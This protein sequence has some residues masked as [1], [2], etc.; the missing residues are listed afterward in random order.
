MDIVEEE[1][2]ACRGLRQLRVR[3]RSLDTKEKIDWTLKLWKQGRQKK[4]NNTTLE[5]EESQQEK[6]NEGE[7]DEDT[8]LSDSHVIEA[9]E[10]AIEERVTRHLLAF[11]KLEAVWLGT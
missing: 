11:A 8:V 4:H 3:I 1:K 9:K 10:T 2:W 7:D 6:E 5:K